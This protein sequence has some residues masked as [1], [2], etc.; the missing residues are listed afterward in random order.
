[1][2]ILDTTLREGE[3]TP[4]VCFPGHVRT[5][6]ADELDRIGIDIIEAG[7]P[8]VTQEIRS[9]VSSIAQR[10]LNAT[11]GAHARSL[12][13]DVDLALE[14]GV[15]FLGVFYC[16]SDWRLNH[17]DR[18]LS[19]AIDRIAWVID[20]AKNRRPN[21]VLRYTPED[22]V[23]SPFS[24]A[25]SAAEAAVQAG[26]DIISVADTTGHMIPGGERSMYD[27]VSRLRE[28]LSQRG[29][30]PEIAVHCHND[31]GLAVANALDGIRAGASIVDVTVLGLGERAG[32]TD[33]ASLLAVLAADFGYGERW[34]LAQLPKLYR[35][36][37]RYAGIPIPANQPVTGSN[38][39]SHCAG[40]HTQAALANPLHYQS[41]DPSLVG[42][43][44]EIAL[45]HMSGLASVC[46]ALESIEGRSD[47]ELAQQVLVEV[48]RIG[49]SGRTVDLDELQLIVNSIELPEQS[50]P[51]G[52]G[53]TECASVSST[54]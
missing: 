42:R 31:R 17:L 48:K 26:A 8:V 37:S 49:Q 11:I 45:D 30:E 50:A 5:A 1:M 29:C 9:S 41:L 2:R 21:L 53:R 18:S 10:G 3:Q 24:N 14:C 44:A 52:L 39:F 19:S 51:R 4:S 43:S 28:A 20:Y 36:V 46:H 15:G 25:V 47:L 7:H 38:A 13:T 33:L 16:V 34:Q 40:V 27:M 12:E 22:T 32:L 54:R 23:R 6:I 35:L